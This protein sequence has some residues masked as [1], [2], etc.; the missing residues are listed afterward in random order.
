M[1]LTEPIDPHQYPMN[2]G[3]RGIFVLFNVMNFTGDSRL[4]RKGSDEDADQMVR[5]FQLM[6]FEVIRVDDPKATE[7]VQILKTGIWELIMM[8]SDRDKVWGSLHSKLRYN[9]LHHFNQ[10]S[11][12]ESI[13]IS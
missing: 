5:T 3:A 7:M 11:T 10:S 12:S 13:R 2:H 1:T 9:I 6:E 8:S 4:K